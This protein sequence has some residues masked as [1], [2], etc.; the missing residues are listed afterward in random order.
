MSI[1]QD[2]A[3]ALLEKHYDRIFG[4]V[5]SGYEGYR[6][7]P[8]RAIHRRSTR[9]SIVNDRILAKIIEEF[10][11]VPGTR[12]VEAK[13]S[14]LRFLEVGSRGLLWFKKTDLLHRPQTYP[15]HHAE[16]IESGAQLPM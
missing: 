12:Y 1:T 7:Y 5:S 10:D 13:Q 2:E 16:R 11:E 9:A 14:N 4:A 3:G 15:T 8:E 6:K